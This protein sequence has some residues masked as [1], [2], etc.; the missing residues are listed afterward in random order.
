[1][2]VKGNLAVSTGTVSIR[3][4]NRLDIIPRSI[5]CVLR[6]A[7]YSCYPTTT[8]DPTHSNP[9]SCSDSL[10]RPFSSIMRPSLLLGV[11]FTTVGF[12][13]PTKWLGEGEHDVQVAPA[14]AR[15]DGS[16]QGL[17]AAH[18]NKRAI[19]LQLQTVT[20]KLNNQKQNVGTL[21]GQSL[22][23]ATSK[24]LAEICAPYLNGNPCAPKPVTIP[25]IAYNNSVA[26]NDGALHINVKDANFPPNHHGLR[27]ALI[28]EIAGV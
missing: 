3:S 9:L 19:G 4:P 16:V 13:V 22:W 1:M 24:A 21:V 18:R 14:P 27:E 15:D 7:S 6:H 5:N 2:L 28:E 20:V 8:F 25:N 17:Y 12:A 10:T 23:D 26:N 11:V